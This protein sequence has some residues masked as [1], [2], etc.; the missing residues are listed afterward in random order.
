MLVHCGC[1]QNEYL[2]EVRTD[3]KAREHD[4]DTVFVRIRFLSDADQYVA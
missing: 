3:H 2:Q 4:G 1:W